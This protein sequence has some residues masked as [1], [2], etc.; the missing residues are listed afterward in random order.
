MRTRTLL[1]GGIALVACASTRD[2]PAARFANRPAVGIVDDRRDVP[3]PPAKITMYGQLDPFDT[4]IQRPLE[5][6]FE[7]PRDRRALGVNSLDQVPDS[8][9]FTNRVSARV[10]TPDEIRNGPLTIESP[11]LHKPWTVTG[12]KFGGTTVGY[13]IND[14]RGLKYLI[15]FDSPEYPEVET[16]T[17]VTV[18]RLLWA[19]GYNVPEDQIAYVR[20]NELVMSPDATVKDPFGSTLKQL[21]RGSLDRAL[22]KVAHEPDGRIRVLISRWLDG[23]VL[24]GHPHEGVREDDPNDRIPHELRRDLRGALPIFAWV[25]HVDLLPSNFVDTWVADPVYPTRH[26]VMHY[27]LDFGM[28][29]GV[30]AMKNN[31][32]RRGY[33]YRIDLVNMFTELLSL[34]LDDRVWERAHGRT[35]RG[36]SDSFESATFDPGKWVPDFPYV[37]FEMADRFDMYWGAKIVSQ[38]SRAQIAAA[39][40]AGRFSD[41][42][43]SAYLVD[44]LLERQ[45]KTVA[46]WFRQVNPVD[47]FAL[48]ARGS[49][50]FDDLSIKNTLVR[51]PLTHYTIVA[52]DHSGRSLGQGVDVVADPSGRTCTPAVALAADH[53]GYT[54]VEIT[55]TRAQFRGTTLV[56]L[57]RR[58]VAMNHGEAEEPQESQTSVI[59]V[60]RE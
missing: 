48:D 57:A 15:K 37:P 30:M 33:V 52:R 5:R 40:D 29:L 34:G 16:G 51:A 3:R 22:A 17:H 55:T 35:L 31:D 56:H 53:D 25:D 24:G 59:G 39:V 10:L 41:P 4:S 32:T 9:W 45:R 20:P 38:F 12:R 47:N 42:N 14:A 26:Y 11:E 36:V 6:T 2:F 23:Q 1:V 49:L 54:I 21:T 13:I 50:C 8:T 60:W 44:T 18:N 19:A 46:Y 7:L 27:L 43:A 28:S 58:G